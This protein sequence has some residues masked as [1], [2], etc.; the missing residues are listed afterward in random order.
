MGSSPRLQPDGKPVKSP[1]NSPN[2]NKKQGLF[3]PLPIA[4]HHLGAKVG[5]ICAQP[6]TGGDQQIK[7]RT[8]TWRA[9]RKI[10]FLSECPKSHSA[11]TFLQGSASSR[12]EA[13]SPAPGGLIFS[14]PNGKSIDPLILGVLTF[15]FSGSSE[16]RAFCQQKQRLMVLIVNCN[17]GVFLPLHPLLV[18]SLSAKKELEAHRFS[19]TSKRSPPAP[20]FRPVFSSEPYKLNT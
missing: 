4:L 16:P 9:K 14:V 18:F 8:I 11:K 15:H 6:K 13:D 2:K 19:F 1:T 12:K 3:P 17:N 10:S 7:I 5:T 20:E